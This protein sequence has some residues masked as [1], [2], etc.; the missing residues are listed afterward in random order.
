VEQL[1]LEFKDKNRNLYLKGIEKVLSNVGIENLDEKEDYVYQLVN[2]G[3]KEFAVAGDYF[4][5]AL[6]YNQKKYEEAATK[7]M[8]VYYL[9]ENSDYAVKSLKLALKAF[10]KLNDK[11]NAEK[12]KNILDKKEE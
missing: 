9:H 10:E 7:L 6:D 8:R 1:S 3:I 2:S 12:V 11:N 4:I 5:A